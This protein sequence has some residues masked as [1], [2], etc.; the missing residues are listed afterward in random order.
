MSPP[1]PP[2]GE[3]RPR[4]ARFVPGPHVPTR[5]PRRGGL[6]TVRVGDRLT[7][8]F[9]GVDPRGA[10]TAR[11]G[12]VRL[13]VPFGVPGEEA[14]VQVTRGGRRAEARIIALLR[15][16]AAITPPRCPHF[17][18]CGG[19]Q[20]QHLDL[21]LQRRLKTRLVKDYLKEH[22]D[23][24][25]DLVAEAVG[26]GGWAYRNTIRVTFGIADGRVAA[27][28]HA[29][30][31]PRLLD[32]QVCPVQHATNEAILRAAREA[33]AALGLPVYDRARGVGIVRGALGLVSFATGEAL[34]VLSTTAPL[35]DPTGL[36]HA[37]ID[38][39]PG[40]VGILSTVQPRPGGDLLGGGLR[41][42]W[43]R[44]HVIDEPAGFRVRV[45]PTTDMPAN[46]EGMDVLLRAVLRAAELRRT[47]TA[48]DLAAATPLV[49]LA[50][51]GEAEGVTGVVPGRRAAADAWDAAR[52]N[53]AGN[54]VFTT[55]P[56]ADALAALAVRRR[57]DVAVLTGAGPGLP[58]ELVAAVAAA[59][60]PRVVYVARAL[61]T[62]ARDLAC[63][64]RAGYQVAGVQP[65]DLLPQTSH[66]HVVAALRRA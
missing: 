64:R 37:L 21:D 54:L 27:G 58:D 1:A 65:V 44:D 15:K 34:V 42:L 43:G 10:A 32:V 9:S 53:G 24:R 18:V 6:G 13:A 35:R 45:R 8:Q 59:G 36:V 46:P 11:L 51:A 57:P 48:V 60:V 14:I 55:R 4:T 33:V 41:L 23:V 22:A 61:A 62:C 26:A 20:W 12:I 56:P 19:C 25:R 28:F 52:W 3:R 31:A 66:V 38:R 29:A 39:A 16:S 2:S 40:L 7:V 50:L 5:H 30:G 49:A 63:W 17:G 47:E